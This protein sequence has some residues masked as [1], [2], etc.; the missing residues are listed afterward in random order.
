MQEGMQGVGQVINNLVPVRVSEAKA[1]TP[2]VMFSK[3]RLHMFSGDCRDAG[4][5]EK[6]TAG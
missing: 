3:G 4:V 6:R 5:A 2:T 1:A